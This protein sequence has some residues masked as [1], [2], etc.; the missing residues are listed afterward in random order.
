MYEQPYE[1]LPLFLLAIS[2]ISKDHPQTLDFAWLGTVLHTGLC[3]C[4]PGP[5]DD[6]RNLIVRRPTSLNKPREEPDQFLSE[7]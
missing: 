1:S 4:K 5:H 3:I 6:A 7:H 2:G